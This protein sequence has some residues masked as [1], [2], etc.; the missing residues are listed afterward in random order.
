MN[1]ALT[2]T[3]FNIKKILSNKKIM[4]LLAVIALTLV[5]V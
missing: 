2:K 3:G 4:I 5:A 1:A